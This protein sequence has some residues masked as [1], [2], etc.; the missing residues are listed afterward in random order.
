M[1]LKARII[2]SDADSV[3]L[4]RQKASVVLDKIRSALSLA[5]EAVGL[6]AT[7]YEN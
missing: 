1:P 6:V 4:L 3:A 5:N 7:S 2:L